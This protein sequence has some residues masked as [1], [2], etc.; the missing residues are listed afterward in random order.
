M[1]RCAGSRGGRAG[2]RVRR[3]GRLVR[4]RAAPS[5]RYA[6]YAFRGVARAHDVG[7]VQARATVVVRARRARGRP[8]SWSLGTPWKWPRSGRHARRAQIRAVRGHVFSLSRSKL[9]TLPAAGD[10]RARV[11]RASAGAV[12]RTPP[13]PQAAALALRCDPLAVVVGPLRVAVC[14]VAVRRGP[15]LAIRNFRRRD[16]RLRAL[17]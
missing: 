6:R 3:R 10:P 14:R 11:G 1:P 15:R 4:V 7:L 2:D 13:G 9:V 5:S 12:D 16:S 17:L 8:L